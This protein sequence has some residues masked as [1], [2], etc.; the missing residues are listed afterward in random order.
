[1]KKGDSWLNRETG[2]GELKCLMILGFNVEN[3]LLCI[4]EMP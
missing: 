1:V 4:A 2:F 3:S